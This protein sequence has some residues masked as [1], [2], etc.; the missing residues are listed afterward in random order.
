VPNV[1]VVL[2]HFHWSRYQSGL[3][4]FFYGEGLQPFWLFAPCERG[5]HDDLCGSGRLSVTPYVHERTELYF[6]SILPC[7]SLFCF[8]HPLKMVPARAFYSSRLGSYNEPPRPDRWPWGRW[9]LHCRAQR[10]GV[11]NDVFNNVGQLGIA[12][13]HAAFGLRYGAVSLRH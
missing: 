10:P 7:L 12:A 11:A 1:K 2:R 8:F 6:C 5:G 4:W 9:T 13:Y 3:L